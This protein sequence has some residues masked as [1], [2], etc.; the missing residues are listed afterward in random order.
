MRQS[1]ALA[2]SSSSNPRGAVLFQLRCGDVAQLRNFEEHVLDYTFQ[3]EVPVSVEQQLQQKNLNRLF[4]EVFEIKTG[5]VY[6]EEGDLR[7][8]FSMESVMDAIRQEPDSR[9]R[10]LF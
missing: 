7:G 8:V 1:G 3:N 2:V 10:R 6:R 4:D 5:Y 9:K